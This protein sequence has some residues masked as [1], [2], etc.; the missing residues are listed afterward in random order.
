M[1]TNRPDKSYPAKTG[2]PLR[3][4]K[5]ALRSFPRLSLNLHIMPQTADSHFKKWLFLALFIFF[6][7]ILS[8][9]LIFWG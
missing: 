8:A 4:K 7:I 2:A 5:T 3:L 1:I 6:L 9:M